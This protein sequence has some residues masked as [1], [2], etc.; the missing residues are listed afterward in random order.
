[1]LKGFSALSL[2]CLLAACASGGAQTSRWNVME[3]DERVDDAYLEATLPGAILV[4]ADG[5]R[6]L[7]RSDGAYTYESGG[8]SYDAPGVYFTADGARCI[9]YPNGDRCDLYVLRDGALTLIN[10][11]GGSFRVTEVIPASG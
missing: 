2:A 9:Q 8:R 3:G 7:Y 1:M 4:Y 10:R 5:A 11:R 6:E